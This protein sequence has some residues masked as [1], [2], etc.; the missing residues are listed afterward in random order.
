MSLKNKILLPMIYTETIPSADFVGGRGKQKKKLNLSE[1]Y[2]S[3]TLQRKC[4]YKIP[5]TQPR[6][7]MF[8]E[9]TVRLTVTGIQ[10]INLYLWL[11]VP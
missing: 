9:N 7:P 4:K 1:L 6:N 3:F 10:E 2:L 5:E 8:P 11:Y